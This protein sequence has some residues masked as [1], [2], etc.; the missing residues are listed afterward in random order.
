M[1]H[2]LLIC[3]LH[4]T[5]YIS[6]SNHRL[7]RARSKALWVPGCTQNGTLCQ[8]GIREYCFKE[9]I[10]VISQNCR[11]TVLNYNR[12]ETS[13]RK[14]GSYTIFWTYEVGGLADKSEQ[15]NVK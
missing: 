3:C 12:G 14:K 6:Y 8:E 13:L 1:Y 15:V 9:F 2:Y 5:C 4:V 7:S 10:N 11:H